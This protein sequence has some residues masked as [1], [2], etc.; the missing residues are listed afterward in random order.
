MASIEQI[1]KEKLP[2]HIAIIMDGNGRWAKKYG[3][4]RVFGHRSAVKS[5]REVTE[6]AAELGI[7]YLTLYAFSK[8]N[9][10]RPKLE[11]NA[12]M[13]LL[14]STIRK[15]AET[16][17]KNKIRLQAIGDIAN[18]PPKGQEE[19]KQAIDL[20]RNNE[21]M[22]LILALS[23]G[24]RWELKEALKEIGD[25]VKS[26]ILQKDEITEDLI[27]AHLNTAGIPDP[28]LMIRT[29]GEMRISNFLLWQLAY[30]ELYFTQTLWPDFRK[31]DLY[32]AIVSYQ[33]RERR[34]GKISEQIIG[35]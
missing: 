29:S 14:V 17:Q 10:D 2:R 9:W 33:N 11:V 31:K 22:T 3:K 30:T 18:L 16:L 19:L 20:T 25:K 35:Q 4:H 28:E 26:G 5:V 7:K 27:S 34:F 24:G 21:R 15:E 8:E 32:D 1:N 13:Q 12:L 6:G 23:Y